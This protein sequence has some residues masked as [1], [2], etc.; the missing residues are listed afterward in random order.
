M[1]SPRTVYGYLNLGVKKCS[2]IC[3]RF[4]GTVSEFPN[5]G[6]TDEEEEEE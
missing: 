5:L 4:V 2:E 1:D 6:A 3:N